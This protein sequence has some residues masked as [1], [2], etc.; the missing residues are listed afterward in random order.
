MSRRSRISNRT[1]LRR[2]DI[3]KERMLALVEI[4]SP[5]GMAKVASDPLPRHLARQGIIAGEHDRR[6]VTHEA[7]ADRCFSGQV[8]RLAVRLS[9][10]GILKSTRMLRP[11]PGRIDVAM[12]GAALSRR[13]EPPRLEDNRRGRLRTATSTGHDAPEEESP[14][15]E[16]RYAMLPLLGH[17][18]PVRGHPR[19]LLTDFDTSSPCFCKS[20]AAS[21]QR[22]RRDPEA[23]SSSPCRAMNYRIERNH[24]RRSSGLFPGAR[25]LPPLGEFP[26]D[27]GM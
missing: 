10:D 23:S 2:S 17:L 5:Q 27:R 6:G 4:G 9:K 13:C 26:A 19:C 15:K 3:E 8:P 25:I 7:E 21:C 18:E 12:T 14:Q 22:V 20:R 16:R 24:S 11:L 1:V